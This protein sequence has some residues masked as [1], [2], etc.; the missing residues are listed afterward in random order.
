LHDLA[1]THQRFQ[2]RQTLLQQ[3]HQWDLQTMKDV[4]SMINFLKNS[5]FRL[6]V[7]N[8]ERK[9]RRKIKFSINKKLLK[10]N[11]WFMVL[12]PKFLLR[13]LM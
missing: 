2:D 1:S 9:K 6:I 10:W 11:L 3:L 7:T 5:Y 13:Y 12:I 4:I 8:F